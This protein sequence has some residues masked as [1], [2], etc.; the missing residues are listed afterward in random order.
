MQTHRASCTR[1]ELFLPPRALHASPR[2]R[3]T[4]PGLA[5]PRSKS[6]ETPLLTA[7]RRRP[8]VVHHCP[9]LPARRCVRLQRLAEDFPRSVVHAN[10]IKAIPE[11][12][13]RADHVVASFEGALEALFDEPAVLVARIELPLLLLAHGALPIAK[14]PTEGVLIGDSPGGGP[15]DDGRGAVITLHGDVIRR[16]QVEIAAEAADLLRVAAGELEHQ[17]PVPIVRHPEAKI[18]LKHRC[19]PALVEVDPAVLQDGWEE[20]Q[21]AV[22]LGLGGSSR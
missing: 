1:P 5:K 11:E 15:G 14:I 20:G 21:H 19:H 13:L 16:I 10:I 4:T 12:I 22:H 9:V 17:V 8:P 2:I 3:T 6:S 18:C 7:S